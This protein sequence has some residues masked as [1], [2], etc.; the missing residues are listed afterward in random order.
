MTWKEALAFFLVFVAFVAFVVV[1]FVLHTK[2]KYG[3]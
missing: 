1:M 2:S 3:V